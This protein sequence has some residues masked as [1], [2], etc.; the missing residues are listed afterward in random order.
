MSMADENA[1]GLVD[2]AEFVPL[3]VG[4]LETIYAR[5]KYE[6]AHGARAVEAAESS[7]AFLLRGM[8]RQDLEDAI[9]KVFVAA[10]KDGSGS[11][12]RREFRDA[13]KSSSLGLT[14]REINVLMSEADDNGDG[15]ISYAEFAPVCF[16]VLSDMLA[17]QIE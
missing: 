2:Y 16:M 17:K 3:A 7:R 15:V 6:A 14:R 13:L 12:S 1:D 10:D 4:V 9:R 5:R 11:L 8:P